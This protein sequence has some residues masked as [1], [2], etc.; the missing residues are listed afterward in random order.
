M[1]PSRWTSDDIIS[2]AAGISISKEAGFSSFDEQNLA[3]DAWTYT[4]ANADVS[5]MFN[6]NFTRALLER[7]HRFVTEHFSQLYQW[8]LWQ[9][10]ELSHK[11]L[12]KQLRDKCYEALATVDATV[13]RLQTGCSERVAALNS[14]WV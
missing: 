3:N 7:R 13:S 5:M 9:T 2:F 8:R 14:Q 4:M 6:D 12:P 11:C 1:L 10:K